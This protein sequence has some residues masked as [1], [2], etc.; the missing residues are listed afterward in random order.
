MPCSLREKNVQL[1]WDL[2]VRRISLFESKLM[3]FLPQLPR[4]VDEFPK[5]APPQRMQLARGSRLGPYEID[6]LIGFGGMGEVDRAR[7]TRLGRVVVHAEC[8]KPVVVV[9]IFR[10]TNLRSAVILL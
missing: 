5:S 1:F 9:P 3:P 10:G 2:H 8:T 7:D 4:S 6:C